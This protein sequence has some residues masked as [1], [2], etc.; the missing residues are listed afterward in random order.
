MVAVKYDTFLSPM[1]S[2]I[3]G[4]FHKTVMP[5]LHLFKGICLANEKSIKLLH[6]KDAI[7]RVII[8][9][10]ASTGFGIP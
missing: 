5:L 10:A 7:L 3:D 4:H 6:M 1:R 9:F 8:K 2:C